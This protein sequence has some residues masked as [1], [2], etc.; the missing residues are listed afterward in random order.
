MEPFVKEIHSI[1]IQAHQQSKNFVIQTYMEVVHSFLMEDISN[2]IVQISHQPLTH[3][4]IYK[5]QQ[6]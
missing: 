3:V 2:A 4:S 5:T 1:G 6:L